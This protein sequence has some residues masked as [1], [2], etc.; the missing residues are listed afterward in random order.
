MRYNQ[1]IK[2]AKARAHVHSDS[3]LCLGKMHSHSRAIAK[4]WNSQNREFQQWN[5][6]ADLSGID[7]EP[8]EFEWNIFPGF[9]SIEISEGF[10]EGFS[11]MRIGLTSSS[12]C[13]GELPRAKRL[14]RYLKGAKA[15]TVVGSSKLEAVRKTVV[16]AGYRLGRLQ[17]STKCIRKRSHDES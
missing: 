11:R 10:S 13:D 4:K 2:R 7:G 5:E 6:N 16:Y 9:T 15:A 8:I 14:A 1:A 3:V 12:R 17:G